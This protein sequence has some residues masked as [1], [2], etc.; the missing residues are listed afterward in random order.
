MPFRY[1]GIILQPAKLPVRVGLDYNLFK[2]KSQTHNTVDLLYAEDGNLYCRKTT[3]DPLSAGAMQRSAGSCGCDNVESVGNGNA[4][5]MDT[6]CGMLLAKAFGS[7]APGTLPEWL[8]PGVVAEFSP[9][10]PVSG[11][12]GAGGSESELKWVPQRPRPDKLF[13]NLDWVVRNI[14]DSVRDNITE[15]ELVEYLARPPLAPNEVPSPPKR[16][17]YDRYTDMVGRK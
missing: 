3:E 2:W 7:L 17:R 11:G 10:S 9:V 16:A 13:P 14:L 12:A 8:K 6:S 1:D 4:A 5:D 15:S